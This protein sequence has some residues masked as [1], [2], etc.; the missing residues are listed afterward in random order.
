M[1]KL[2]QQYIDIID[3][4]EISL[5]DIDGEYFEGVECVDYERVANQFVGKTKDVGV[6]FGLWLSRFCYD[7]IS[8][9]SEYGYSIKDGEWLHGEGLNKITTEQAF[10]I[11]LK[12]YE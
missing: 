2:E 7:S 11:F 3:S 6:K 12:D 1:N 9:F 5:T 8:A 10:E 4:Y